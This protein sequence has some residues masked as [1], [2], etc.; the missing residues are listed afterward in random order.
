MLDGS[1]YLQMIEE[2]IAESRTK[3]G[4]VMKVNGPADALALVVA[5]GFG[6]GLSP[7]A[8]GTFGS[9]L[10]VGLAY[11]LISNL[12]LDILVLQNALLLISLLVTLLGIWAGT[13]A[14]R[15]F[16]RKDA[17]QIVID[18][19]AGQLIAFVC[20]APYS[21]RMGGDW[22][23]AFIAA[24]ALFRLFDIFKPY[25]IN[26]LQDLT[27]GFG[28]MMDDVLAGIYAALSLS[29]ILFFIVG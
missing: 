2:K 8:P 27:G 25:P 12:R 14:E 19:V 4:R 13:R 15:I 18:E 1:R 5:T 6:V 22:W 28:V 16:E 21:G 24:F 17:S 29:F 11:L 3:R 26:K 7:I 9:L 20:V 10:G 23:W